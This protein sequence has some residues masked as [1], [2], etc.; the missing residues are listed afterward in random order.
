[1]GQLIGSTA[2]SNVLWMRGKEMERYVILMAVFKEL[3]DKGLI[4]DNEFMQINEELKEKYKPLID[5]TL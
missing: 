1:M 4:T 5:L 3:K 2:L